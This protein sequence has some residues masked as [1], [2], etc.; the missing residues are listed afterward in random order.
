MASVPNNRTDQQDWFADTDYDFE[1]NVDLSG[2]MYAQA[3]P[4]QP[5]PSIEI[6][7]EYI[8]PTLL[9][10]GSSDLSTFPGQVDHNYPT[11]GTSQPSVTRQ[12]FGQTPDQSQL[13]LLYQSPDRGFMSQYLL[14]HPQ[15]SQI[16]SELSE[17]P[18][19]STVW[20]QV[21]GPYA[22]LSFYKCYQPQAHYPDAG[23][24]GHHGALSIPPN[25]QAYD[26]T[27]GYHTPLRGMIYPNANLYGKPAAGTC[28]KCGCMAHFPPCFPLVQNTKPAQ[29]LPAQVLQSGQRNSAPNP[30]WMN[31]DPDEESE[32]CPEIS[33][34]K[35]G[36]NSSSR[37]VSRAAKSKTSR[38]RKFSKKHA[39]VKTFNYTPCEQLLA[40]NTEDG[41][42]ISYLPEGQ[43]D[44]DILFTAKEL[45]DYLE[46][47]PR[48]PRVWLQNTPSKCKERL[49]DAD[50]KCRYSEC[51]AKFGTILHGWHRVALDE[52]H[53]RTTE[54]TKD[55]FKMAGVMH[56]WCFEQCIDPL[57]PIKNGILF[58]DDRC[59][60]PRE[61]SNPMAITRD[62]YKKVIDG[63]IKPWYN[64][65][66]LVGVTQG[67]Y[68]KH[69]NTLSWALCNFHVK[70]QNSARERTRQK[71]NQDKPDD[72]KK[73]MEL[74]MGDLAEYHRRADLAKARRG[75][76]GYVLS[77][78]LA[79]KPVDPPKVERASPARK[80]IAVDVSEYPVQDVIGA[81][82][83]D[84]SEAEIAKLLGE[85]SG[86][87]YAGVRPLTPQSLGT[88]TPL[89][90]SCAAPAET[91]KMPF[92]D[93]LAIQANG[94]PPKT[95]DSITIPGVVALQV[96]DS[97][98]GLGSL[99]GSP[100][101]SVASASSTG[102]RKRSR[103]DEGV[104]APESPEPKKRRQTPSP[105]PRSS[106]RKSSRCSL[107]ARSPLKRHGGSVQRV[108]V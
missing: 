17:L 68:E 36:R 26:Q 41:C 16:K 83:Y 28:L 14:Q 103:D 49:I 39:N 48:K 67:P 108:S 44:E 104:A 47:C 45:R 100:T 23:I 7:D 74:I 34:K 18:Q 69:Q 57:E 1:S 13:P 31:E 58:P 37:L 97:P 38:A 105:K 91:A 9:G 77:N 59:F 82:P 54:G 60:I 27:V 29:S 5:F 30:R 95:Q 80:E 2:G 81:E 62:D 56:L 101:G 96:G 51:P 15:S 73:T 42:Q 32:E 40:W 46:Q 65:R 64:E 53:E 102:S 72:E 21:P 19:Q 10:D 63:A 86:P 3:F 93:P 87:D 79:S 4:D 98:L 52:F 8:D 84:F 75:Y 43:L 99:F 89:K 33:T 20:S 76:R 25:P 90:A 71:R 88:K 107:G 12:K 24:S 78:G 70:H 106:L 35:C 55:P 6:K 85:F 50:V 92:I 94:S 22:P 61:K 11:Y 66:L